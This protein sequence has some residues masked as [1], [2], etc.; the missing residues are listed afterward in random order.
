MRICLFVKYF[1]NHDWIYYNS[2]VQGFH[3]VIITLRYTKLPKTVG[4]L[5]FFYESLKMHQIMF[6]V[7]CL[8]KVQN[9]CILSNSR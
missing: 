4:K 9:C 5:K 7:A 3:L 1:K 2:I 8:N 6:T